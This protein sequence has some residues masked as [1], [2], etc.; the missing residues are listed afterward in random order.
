MMSGD[1]IT[2]RMLIAALRRCVS[3]P[4]KFSMLYPAI[5]NSL[6]AGTGTATAVMFGDATGVVSGS[7]L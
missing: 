7:T 2:V 1:R 3:L 4:V 5:V 6:A